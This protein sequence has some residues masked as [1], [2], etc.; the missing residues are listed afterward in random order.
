MNYFNRDM[1]SGGYERMSSEDIQRQV[2]EMDGYRTFMRSTTSHYDPIFT[3]IFVGIGFTGSITIGAA[4][5]TTAAIASAIA[6][7]ALS[8]GLQYLLAPKPP[9]P[10]DGKQPMM[11]AIPYRHWV[12]GRRRLA[13]AYMLWEAKGAKLY[14]VQAIAGHKISAIN[15]YWLHDDEVTLGVDGTVNA[16]ADSR[17]N[18]QVKV[19]SR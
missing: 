13:G 14:A 2:A 19:W 1:H 15:K 8:I 6:T 3:P 4:T 7:T 5:I 9:K 12:V 10:D 17:Y 16:L 11:Q 18:L